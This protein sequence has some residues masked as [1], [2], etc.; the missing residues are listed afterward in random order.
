MVY[1]S[2]THMITKFI[3][4]KEFRQNMAKISN[5]ALKKNQRLIVLR[6]NQ[7]IFELRPLTKEGI[8][9]ESVMVKIKRAE[10]DVR[11]GRVYTQEEIEKKYGLK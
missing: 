4:L 5:Q 1:T 6:K 2:G 10:E 11:Q 9:L 7:P 3:G 8:Y